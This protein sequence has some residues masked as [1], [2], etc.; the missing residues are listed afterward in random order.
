[1]KSLS[2][3]LK[4]TRNPVVSGKNVSRLVDTLAGDTLLCKRYNDVPAADVEAAARAI[5]AEAFDALAVGGGA[6]ASIDFVKSYSAAANVEPSEGPPTVK[7]D[8]DFKP[9]KKEDG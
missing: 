1:M 3:P 5:E 9:Q 8:L 2:I 7:A 4:S 6:A